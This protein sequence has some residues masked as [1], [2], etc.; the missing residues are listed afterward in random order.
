[1]Y[2][3]LGYPLI[4]ISERKGMFFSTSAPQLELAKILS[5]VAVRG[6]FND[7][8]LLTGGLLQS[9]RDDEI[10]DSGA[11]LALSSRVL[12]PYISGRCS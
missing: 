11:V 8:M 12:G 10:L 7:A 1:M 5:L 3:P 9:F 4:S 2:S 6:K